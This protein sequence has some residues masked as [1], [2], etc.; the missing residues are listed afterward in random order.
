VADSLLGYD[1]RALYDPTPQY[2]EGRMIFFRYHSLQDAR[3]FSAFIA[4]V[5]PQTLER[6]LQG[7]VTK[8]VDDTQPH[9]RPKWLNTLGK[10]SGGS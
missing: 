4:A 10:P 1:L 2:R 8:P 3:E 7:R 9:L 5:L 6:F